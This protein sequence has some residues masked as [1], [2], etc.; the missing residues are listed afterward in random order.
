MKIGNI[1]VEEVGAAMAYKTLS[2]MHVGILR[3]IDSGRFDLDNV[4]NE[5]TLDIYNELVDMGLVEPLTNELTE[6]GERS[7]QFATKY[8]SYERR[9]RAKASQVPDDYDD[10]DNPNDDNDDID[11]PQFSID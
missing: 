3:K 8:G 4:H 2:P 7:L 10:L 1:I 6:K 5:N 11:H 9:A